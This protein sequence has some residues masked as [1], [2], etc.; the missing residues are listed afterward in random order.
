MVQREVRE[1]EPD[2]VESTVDATDKVDVKPDIE[3]MIARDPQLT[4]HVA[5]IAIQQPPS[6]ASSEEPQRP[7]TANYQ[8]EPLFSKPSARLGPA[9]PP[10]R[11]GRL[12]GSKSKARIAAV[13]ATVTPP[14]RVA[15]AKASVRMAARPNRS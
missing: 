11:P 14:V 7:G 10:R 1:S 9:V 4:A 6:A 5:A 12:K 15:T 13:T 8:T 2:S 3:A